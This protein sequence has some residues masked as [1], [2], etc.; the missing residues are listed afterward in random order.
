MQ[1]PRFA[2]AVTDK[3]GMR[4]GHGSICRQRAVTSSE[5]RAQPRDQWP[6]TAT[7]AIDTVSPAAARTVQ[8]MATMA[9]QK[10]V[11]L[12]DHRR[13][14][15]P[16]CMQAENASPH[17]SEVAPTA[18]TSCCG[19]SVSAHTSSRPPTREGPQHFHR[20]GGGFA[21]VRSMAIFCTLM[22][23]AIAMAA[24]KAAPSE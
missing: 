14:S 2:T 3:T 19:A 17:S 5:L 24:P 22:P 9:S 13:I 8:Q 20:K 12:Q 15:P 18:V 7:S 11:E 1:Q 21:R 6:T 10:S 16:L 4:T 23:R